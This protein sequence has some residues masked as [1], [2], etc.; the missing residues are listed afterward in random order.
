[1]NINELN[2]VSTINIENELNSVQRGSGTF[3]EI[4]DKVYAKEIIPIV[5]NNGDIIGMNVNTQVTDL[6]ADN[7][8]LE[9]FR[10]K[11]SGKNLMVWVL[12]A[13]ELYA[14]GTVIGEVI[15]NADGIKVICGNGE[16]VIIEAAYGGYS[17]TYREELPENVDV[18]CDE[19]CDG[20][21]RDLDIGEVDES[22]IKTWLREKYDH[23]LAGNYDGMVVE[24]ED[25]V[26]HITNIRWGRKR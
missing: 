26:F 22:I 5:N 2:R 19:I 18:T 13:L 24:K 14:K 1:M 3:K 8:E 21:G 23:Y 7:I 9:K 17:R 6:V 11:Y 20:L 10:K 4:L 16:E 15:E 25:E 12:K